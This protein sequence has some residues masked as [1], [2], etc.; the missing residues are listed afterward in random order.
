[1]SSHVSKPVLLAG[2]VLVGLVFSSFTSG[3]S[4]FVDSDQISVVPDAPI[5]LKPGDTVG[6]TFVVRHGGWNGIQLWLEPSP[7][8]TG[9]LVLHVRAAPQSNVDRTQVVLPLEN[10]TSPGFYQFSFPADTF[11][12]G[13]YQ[14]AFLEFRGEGVVHI[15]AAAGEA[16]QDGAAYQNHQP[17]D[18]QL[19]FRL[20]YN[21]AGIAVELGRGTLYAL[22]LLV[23][24]IL[25]YVIPGAALLTL[26]PYQLSLPW[27]TRISLAVGLSLALYPLLLLWTDLAGLHIGPLYAWLPPALGTV[28]LIWQRRHALPELRRRSLLSSDTFWPDFTLLVVLVFLF[29]VRL[30]VVRSIDIPM[31]G[32]SYQHAV[33]AQLLMDNDGLFKSWEPYTPYRSLTV[34][35]GFPTTVALFAWITGTEIAQATL[36]VGQILNGLAALTLYPLAVRIARGNRWAGVAAVSVA[37]LLSP[38]PAFYVNWGRYAQ[39]AGQVVLPVALWFLWEAT[40]QNR[41]PRRSIFLAGLTLAGMALHYY[42][43]PFYYAVFALAWTVSW[44]IPTFRTDKQRWITVIVRMTLIA[45]IAFIFLAPWGFRVAQS[46]LAQVTVASVLKTSPRSAWERVLAEY[47]IWRD[48]SWYVPTYLLFA[49]FAAILW[50][51]KRKAWPVV[52]CALWGVGLS[53]LVAGQL[54][55][56]PGA[57]FMQNFAVLIA[58]YMPVGLIVGWLF[59]EVVAQ[60]SWWVPV[61]LTLVLIL[62]TLPSQLKIVDPSFALVTRP[63]VRAMA[64][65]QEHTPPD[66]RFL[67]EGFRIYGGRS[68]VGS[69]AGWWIPLLARRENTMP[70]QYALLNEVPAR[71]QYSQE[72]VDLVARLEQHA[73]SSAEGL[74]MLC[75]WGITHVYIGQRQGKAGAGAVQLFSPDDFSNSPAFYLLYHQDRVWIFG[76]NPDACSDLTP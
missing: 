18:K 66:A 10:V 3:C 73:P 37:G 21:P 25:L 4:S 41:F 23:V 53:A 71:P 58:L 17:L 65:I 69:D 15:G 8:A 35:F 43:M 46:R 9:S 7:D 12:H 64:W 22:G 19:A 49:C 62:G 56:L 13:K 16:Y 76:L 24:V 45:G 20:A 52:A 44:G 32:D 30:L 67:V 70:P 5:V 34:H 27:P 11:S 60:R 40:T 39:L 36:L 57:N 28:V 51:L 6:Q 48:I 33:I 54:L 68:A 29:G 74:K 59:G 50:S 1:M 47:R 26:L 72:V 63:D 55:R 31:W 75:K 38:M 42:R 2:I 14:Y 61:L